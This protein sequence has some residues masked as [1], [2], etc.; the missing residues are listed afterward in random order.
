MKL[1]EIV[2]N[3]VIDSRKL[4]EYAL[5]PNNPKGADKAIMFERHLGFTKNN[6]QLLKK[7]IEMT[8]LDADA[9][10]QK[11]DIHGQRYQVDLEITG[12]RL[13]QQEIVRTGWIVEQN[14]KVARLVT[15]YVKRKNESTRT[16]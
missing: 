16:I 14:S 8:A 1:R 15:L 5:N 12:I 3:I 9:T 13:G 4:T 6:Y 7:Q 10:L 2:T 11:T